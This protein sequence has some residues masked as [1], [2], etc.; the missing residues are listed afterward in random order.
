MSFDHHPPL[1]PPPITPQNL[2]LIQA[3]T[4]LTSDSFGLLDVP[5]SALCWVQNDR[6]ALVQAAME[7]LVGVCQ[8]AGP[9]FMMRRVQTEAWPVL[10]HLLKQG[11]PERKHLPYSAGDQPLSRPI[12]LRHTLTTTVLVMVE[13]NSLKVASVVNTD[14]PGC[15]ISS[16]RP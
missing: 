1:P 2:S 16:C 6:P 8:L 4:C 12:L 5:A 3:A 10:V 9:Q 7:C 11:R 13:H 15:D 14:G